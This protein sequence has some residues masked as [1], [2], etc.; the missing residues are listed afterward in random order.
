LDHR[1][2]RLRS[3]QRQSSHVV[4]FSLFVGRKNQCC[5]QPCLLERSC[6]RCA[7]MSCKSIGNERW[8]AHLFVETPC[9]EGER[10][11]PPRCGLYPHA[12]RCVDAPWCGRAVSECDGVMKWML[13]VCH[14]RYAMI[15][16][17]MAMFVERTK[18]KGRKT[19]QIAKRRHSSD[20]IPIRR[21]SLHPPY[22]IDVM[23]NRSRRRAN[24]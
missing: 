9:D 23:K 2:C 11:E 3:V 5:C 22:R 24:R 19:R 20:F 1:S 14:G 21:N 13:E 7:R 12:R 10:E 8:F 17:N 18:A 15:T 6:A 4:V 16:K